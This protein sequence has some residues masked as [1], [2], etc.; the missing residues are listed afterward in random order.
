MEQSSVKNANLFLNTRR[1]TSSKE[2]HLTEFLAAIIDMD[3]TF[4]RD[5]SALL[6]GRYAADNGWD[7]PL[8]SAVET[9]VQFP[10]TNCCP[11]MRFTL[12]DGHTIVCENKIE[13]PQTMGSASDPRAQLLR[14]LDLA[15]DGVAYIR[16]TP[17]HNLAQEIIN[18]PKFICNNGRHFLWRDIYPLL[19]K[20]DNPLVAAVRKGF[21]VMGFVPP[22]PA[23]GTMADLNSS[24]DK[25]NRCAFREFWQLAAEYGRQ[26]GWRVETNVN[27]ELYYYSGNSDQLYQVF[28]SPSKAE[29]FLLRL[30]LKDGADVDELSQLVQRVDIAVPYEIEVYTKK[31]KRGGKSVSENVIDITTSLK[32]VIG[33]SDDR[34][35]IQ[36]MLLGF[37]KSFVDVVV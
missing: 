23:V 16:A 33:T 5:F 10:D 31:G 29:R 2:D 13:A 25:K 32:H 35:E 1:L 24:V 36:T 26:L 15:C 18:H 34:Q 4:R 3:E 6:L 19:E 22:L 8:I 28:V 12:A 37:V 21:E 20:N 14:Y 11:D 27:A 9:Q 30:T 17:A 7:T